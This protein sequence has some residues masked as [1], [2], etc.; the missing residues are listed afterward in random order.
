MEEKVEQQFIVDYMREHEVQIPNSFLDRNF[1][2]SLKDCEYELVSE[3]EYYE[4]VAELNARYPNRFMIPFGQS[5]V[6]DDVVG[7]LADK[8]TAIGKII[9]I[10]DFADQGWEGPTYYKSL[11]DWLGQE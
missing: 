7:F 3:N 9:L 4:Y 2:R 5:M 1:V 11:T 8:G 10:H 6:D